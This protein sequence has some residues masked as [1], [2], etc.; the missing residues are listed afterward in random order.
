[1]KTVVV[2]II[3]GIFALMIGMLI[4]R[5]TIPVQLT[6]TVDIGMIDA[7]QELINQCNQIQ[8]PTVEINCI[9]SDNPRG[10]FCFVD[11]N[12]MANAQFRNMQFEARGFTALGSIQSGTKI[13]P[14]PDN[15]LETI[16]IVPIFKDFKSG[17][18]GDQ[19]SFEK[20]SEFT[21]EAKTLNISKEDFSFS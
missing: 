9:S 14:N 1:M 16:S 18:S 11:I 15:R 4:G 10:D 17:T 3:V 6:E 7:P 19:Y 8:Y 21:C 12:N 5:Q 13:V 20:I 2:A